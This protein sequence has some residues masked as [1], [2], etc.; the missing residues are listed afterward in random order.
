MSVCSWQGQ[1]Y[2]LSLGVP[3]T[4][5]NRKAAEQKARQ[6]ELDFRLW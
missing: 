3:D 5:I 4:A 6:I 1:R 2:Y